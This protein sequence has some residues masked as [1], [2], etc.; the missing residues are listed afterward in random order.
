MTFIVNQNGKVFQR[1]LGEK[2]ARIAG[3]MREYNPDSNW[4]L[5]SDQGITDAVA[6][7]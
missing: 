6:G 5:V 1:D 2:T 4:T 3:A 7:K